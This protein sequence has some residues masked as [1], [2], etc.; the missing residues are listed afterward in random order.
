MFIIAK[1]TEPDDDMLSSLQAKL[2]KLIHAKVYKF[3]LQKVLYNA[4]ASINNNTLGDKDSPGC[5]R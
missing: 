2:A 5:T 4:F 1:Y 3:K